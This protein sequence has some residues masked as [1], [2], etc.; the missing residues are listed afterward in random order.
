MKAGEVAQLIDGELHGDPNFEIEGVSSPQNP[1]PRTAV[2]CQSAKDLDLVKD[3][4]DLLFV[5][6]FPTD[7]KPRIEV[8]EVRLSLAIFLEKMYPERHPSGVSD[9]AV[10]GKNVS[11]GKDVYIAPYSVIGDNVVLEDGVKVY[12]FTYIGDN[13]FVGTGSIIFSGVQ[14][15]PN[16]VIGKGVRIHSGVVLG[17]DGFGYH[18]GDNIIKKLPHIGNVVIED[19]VELGANTTVD[20]ALLDS[21]RVGRFTKVDNLVVI[22]HNCIVG[23]GNIIVGQSGLAGSVVTGKG[24][25]MGGQVAVRDHVK[26]GD[27]VMLVARSAVSKDLEPNKV[28]GGGIPAMEWSK[29]KR[30][31]AIIIKLPDLLKKFK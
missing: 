22:A 24:V 30:I 28:Y 13:S 7:V 2:F 29:W 6:G 19:G 9:K 14:I 12:P 4:D 23:E 21:T 18:L 8:K 10:I 25:I 31:Y 3:R 26:I 1:K 5:V 27:R 16:T 20:R 15:Y 17:A 11:I